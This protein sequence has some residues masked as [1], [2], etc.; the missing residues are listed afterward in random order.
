MVHIILSQLLHGLINLVVI[1]SNLSLFGFSEIKTNLKLLAEDGLTVHGVLSGIGILLPLEG[2][3]GV[4]LAG[5]VHVG[6]HAELLKFSLN[7]IIRLTPLFTSSC[8]Y[9]VLE[10]ERQYLCLKMLYEL[11]R[12]LT[13]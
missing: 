2:D 7:T 12:W 9:N 10:S 6:H 1:S 8:K 3:E 13:S 5:V 4:S 11:G